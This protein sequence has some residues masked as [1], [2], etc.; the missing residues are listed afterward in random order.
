MAALEARVRDG[1]NTISTLQAEAGEL[2]EE[3]RQAKNDLA[4]LNRKALFAHVGGAGE[5]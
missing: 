3:L 5:E 1:E 2:Q 4:A